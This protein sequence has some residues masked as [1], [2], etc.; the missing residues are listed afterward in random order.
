MCVCERGRREG[1]REIGYQI[2]GDEAGKKG[3]YIVFNPPTTLGEG[4]ARKQ[5]PVTVESLHRTG[6]V[7]GEFSNCTG[8]KD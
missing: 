7:R 1:Q 2:D 3:R 6:G 8:D 5:M 4:D